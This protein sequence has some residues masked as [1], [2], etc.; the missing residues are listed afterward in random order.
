SLCNFDIKVMPQIVISWGSKSLV[1]EG[2]SVGIPFAP[3]MLVVGR[4]RYAAD[5]SR[6]APSVMINIL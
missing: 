1:R 4:S 3:L 6:Q 2:N 5:N